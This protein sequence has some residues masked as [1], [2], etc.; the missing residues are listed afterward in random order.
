MLNIDKHNGREQDSTVRLGPLPC[1][2]TLKV[3]FAEM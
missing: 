3:D 2:Q 1:L